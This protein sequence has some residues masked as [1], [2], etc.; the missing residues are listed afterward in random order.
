MERLERLLREHSMELVECVAGRTGMSQGEARAF[1][2]A[3]GPELLASYRW[4]SDGWAHT[5]DHAA[6][7]REV[8]SVMNVR[9][10]GPRAGMS[11][12]RTWAGLR[13]LVPAVLG[14]DP[15]VTG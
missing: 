4:Q 6:Q 13:A 5:G 2:E 9:E 7:A 1:L 8:L 11:S 10:I 15:V 12:E 14:G 3:A